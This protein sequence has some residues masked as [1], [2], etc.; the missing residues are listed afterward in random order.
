VTARYV[1]IPQG[2]ERCK[3]NISHKTWI[4]ENTCNI[5][6]SSKRS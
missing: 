3:I 4:G 6:Q 1:I 5:C 2:S